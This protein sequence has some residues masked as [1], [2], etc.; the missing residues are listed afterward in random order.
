MGCQVCQQAVS[1]T[2]EQVFVR[3]SWTQ[4]ETPKMLLGINLAGGGAVMM[5][6]LCG[7]E[8]EGL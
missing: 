6:G 3:S 4:M 1:G 5:P 7:Q 2:V 8:Q